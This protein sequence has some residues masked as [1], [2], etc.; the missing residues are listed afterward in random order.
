MIKKALFLLLIFGLLVTTVAISGCTTPSGG[1][2]ISNADQASGAIT[3][4]SRNVND[5]ASTLNDI[6]KALG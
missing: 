6:D 1:S 5:V 2:S 4:I 3:N